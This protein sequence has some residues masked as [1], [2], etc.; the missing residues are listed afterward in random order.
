[1]QQPFSI[2][3][4]WRRIPSQVFL[5]VRIS[6][7]LTLTPRSVSEINAHDFIHHRLTGSVS[8]FLLSYDPDLIIIT[9]GTF[10]CFHFP[11]THNVKCDGM[12]R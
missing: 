10:Y 3:L 11:K 12:N 2:L 8:V 4:V 9:R 7:H 1:M 5:H 6:T